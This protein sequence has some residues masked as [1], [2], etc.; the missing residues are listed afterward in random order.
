MSEQTKTPEARSIDEFEHSIEGDPTAPNELLQFSDKSSAILW[1]IKGQQID[2]QTGKHTRPSSQYNC[3][4]ITT[5][6]GIR[7]AFG[8]GVILTLPELD[9]DTG[10]FKGDSYPAR[11][12]IKA[13]DLDLVAPQGLPKGIVGEIW[14]FAPDSGTVESVMARYKTFN[15]FVSENLVAMPNHLNSAM[16]VLIIASGRLMQERQD[17]GGPNDDPFAYGVPRRP[18]RPV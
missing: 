13:D 2:W 12:E 8:A 10:R 18:I 11:A 15:A 17:A 3:T 16:N 6:S 5:S 4:I 1:R 14:P 9:E 7:I